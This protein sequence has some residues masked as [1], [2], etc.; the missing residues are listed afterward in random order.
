MRNATNM[1]NSIPFQSLE[2]ILTLAPCIISR[3]Y[4]M[5]FWWL[6]Y[7]THAHFWCIEI[8]F[9]TKM[10]K[11]L[12]NSKDIESLARSLAH[13]RTRRRKVCFFFIL[14]IGVYTFEGVKWYCHTIIINININTIPFK[15]FTIW[16]FM[17]IQCEHR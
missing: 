11:H 13:W 10:L 9:R 5:I 2:T 15:L 14:C 6:S 1:R 4:S 7:C 12:A 8:V 17:P 3:P 16:T